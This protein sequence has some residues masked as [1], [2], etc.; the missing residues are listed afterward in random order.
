MTSFIDKYADG[1]FNML[2]WCLSCK[3]RC[4]FVPPP[5]WNISS[6]HMVCSECQAACSWSAPAMARAKSSECPW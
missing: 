2:L 6:D 1:E 4:V 3:N 5:L